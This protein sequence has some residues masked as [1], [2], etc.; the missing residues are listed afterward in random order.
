MAGE[1]IG[2]IMAILSPSGGSIGIGF[3]TPAATVL[4]VIDQLEKFGETRRGWLGVHIQNVD[5]TIAESLNFPGAARSSLEPTTR[6]RPRRRSQGRGR[7]RQIFDGIEIKESR[8]LP[9]IVAAA[10]VGKDVDIV[11][12][13]QGKQ[14]TKTIKLGRLEDNDKRFL[15]AKH[16]EAVS[17][18]SPAP[19]KRRSEWNF[20]ASQTIWCRNSPSRTMSPPES[21]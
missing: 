16:G 7:H 11:V 18:R 14:I 1:V 15:G 6:D 19:S 8:D 21:S 17:R 10:P 5:D 3:A 12:I 2:I 9:K 20:P 4:P 13:R